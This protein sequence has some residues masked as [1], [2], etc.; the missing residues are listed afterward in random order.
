[1]DSNFS[2]IGSVSESFTIIFEDR[3]SK[4]E[5]PYYDNNYWGN[6]SE[7]DHTMLNNIDLDELLNW[8]IYIKLPIIKI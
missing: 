6:A 3:E 4:Q 8:L 1:M 5:M 7:Q 2:L